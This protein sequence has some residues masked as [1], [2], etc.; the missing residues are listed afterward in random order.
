MVYKLTILIGIIIVVPIIIGIGFCILLTSGFPIFYFQKRIGKYEKEFVLYKF[1]TMQKNAQTEQLALMKKNEANG[2]VFKIRD[3]PRFTSIGKLLS[4]TGLDELPQ[5]FNVLRGDMAVIGPRPLP[6]PEARK[7]KPW[8][9]E[10]HTVLPGIIS[11]WI[12]QGYHSTPFNDW[13]KSDIAYA[14]T[15][16]FTGDIGI[17]FSF[18]FYWTQLIKSTVIDN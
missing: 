2:P 5:L 1:R 6:V 12:F 17:F 16:N 4:R 9:R 14:K 10:R 8:Q 15:K 18:F 13:M 11:P 7:L 3:D